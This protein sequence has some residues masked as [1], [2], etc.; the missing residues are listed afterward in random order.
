M[1]S[2]LTGTGQ[3]PNRAPPMDSYTARATAHLNSLQWKFFNFSHPS[4]I[5]QQFTRP[6]YI[7][8]K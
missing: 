7:H 6:S 2:S 3:F 1:F 8:R 5:H 4:I